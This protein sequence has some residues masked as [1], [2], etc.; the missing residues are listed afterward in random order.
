MYI[1]VCIN[2]FVDND[3]YVNYAM[4][5]F[6]SVID[7]FCKEGC[8]TSALEILQEH[9]RDYDL[10][11]YG[12]MQEVFSHRFLV[13]PLMTAVDMEYR[14]QKLIRRCFTP[15]I[16]S[17]IQD[18]RFDYVY[19]GGSLAKLST[20]EIR[21]TLRLAV[22]LLRA[23]TGVFAFTVP[24]YDKRLGKP[25]SKITVGRETEIYRREFAVLSQSGEFVTNQSVFEDLPIMSYDKLYFIILEMIEQYGI[26]V[27]NHHVCDTLTVNLRELRRHHLIPAASFC[28]VV[29]ASPGWKDLYERDK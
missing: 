13:N 12:R 17:T 21:S 19:Y 22:N 23:Q 2:P 6:Q 18:A 26:K 20:D 16:M 27:V 14:D 29:L 15:S 8:R 24:I 25:T 11:G 1:P 5:F 9:N 4:S 3:C 10:V 28:G 7:N